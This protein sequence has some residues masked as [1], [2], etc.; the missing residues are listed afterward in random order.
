MA[1]LGDRDEGGERL[2]FGAWEMKEGAGWEVE[3]PKDDD[4]TKASQS[5]QKRQ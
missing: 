4:M 2:E 5:R 1:G 3:M